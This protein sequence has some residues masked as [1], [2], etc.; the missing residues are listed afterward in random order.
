MRS[1]LVVE[2]D[3]DYREH[4]EMLLSEAGYCVTTAGCADEAFQCLRRDEF[5]L[6]LCDLHLPFALDERIV[7]YE[8]SVEVGIRTINE[9][10]WVFPHLPIV[11]MTAALPIDLDRLASEQEFVPV[12]Y[13]PFSRTQLMQCLQPQAALELMQ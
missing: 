3:A 2:D 5:D 6:L 9:L 10:R 12:L 7:R 13:K 1:I 4:L 11:A 8:Y